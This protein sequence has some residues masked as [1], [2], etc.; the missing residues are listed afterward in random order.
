MYV[1]NIKDDGHDT[2]TDFA[3]KWLT[4]TFG[5]ILANPSSLGD[6]LLILTFDESG[7]S[8]RNQ[9]YTAVLGANVVPGVKNNQAVNHTALLK[10]VEDELGTGNLGRDDAKA[11]VISGI[12]K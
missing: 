9:I 12:W 11:L 7:A 1:P 10:M 8:P 2:G 5:D 4:A 3:G 6:T